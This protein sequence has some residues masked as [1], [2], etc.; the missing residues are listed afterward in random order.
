[1]EGTTKLHETSFPLMGAPGED[2]GSVKDAGAVA[3][4]RVTDTGGVDEIGVGFSAGRVPGLR[5]G[6]VFAVDVYGYPLG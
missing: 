3:T 2:L 1:V 5:F 6:G 4:R